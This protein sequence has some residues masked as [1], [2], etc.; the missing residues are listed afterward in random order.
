M[1][2]LSLYAYVLRW[3]RL[4]LQF[5]LLIQHA[6]KRV[7]SLVSEVAAA[8]APSNLGDDFVGN[9]AARAAAS[10]YWKALQMVNDALDAN[11]INMMSFCYKVPRA[12]GP[13]T[14]SEVF[15]SL[16]WHMKQKNDK[17]VCLKTYN[18]FQQRRLRAAYSLFTRGER[19]LKIK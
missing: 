15:A 5:G 19:Q 16:A 10:R 8:G 3:F 1:Q 18:K 13:V 9:R 2:G 11:L 7:G 12:D 17:F 4:T 14:V 6:K